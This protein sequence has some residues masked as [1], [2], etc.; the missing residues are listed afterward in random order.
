MLYGFKTSTKNKKS[1][2]WNLFEYDFVRKHFH[3]NTIPILFFIPSVK[4]PLNS[5]KAYVSEQEL[6]DSKSKLISQP[7]WWNHD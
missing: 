6:I 4:S 1:E 7:I 3:I 2:I 5:L